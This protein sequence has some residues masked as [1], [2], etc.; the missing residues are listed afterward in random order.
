MKSFSSTALSNS[1]WVDFIRSRIVYGHLSTLIW[2]STENISWDEVFTP[3]IQKNKKTLQ[4]IHII[5]TGNQRHKVSKSLKLT[6]AQFAQVSNLSSLYL[7]EQNCFLKH[8]DLLPI[9]LQ[10]LSIDVIYLE[11][12]ELL[13]FIIAL[14]Q[15]KKLRLVNN[16]PEEKEQPRMSVYGVNEK[17]SRLY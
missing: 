11:S 12:S 13:Y 5:C 3:V 6:C 4:T 9:S 15:L 16:I 1:Y 2:V 17:V 10:E 14:T 8:L 7:L